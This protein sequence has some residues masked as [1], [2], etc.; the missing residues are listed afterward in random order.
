[1]MDEIGEQLSEVIEKDEPEMPIVPKFSEKYTS[2][3][4]LCENEI[5]ENHIFEKL[6]I[7]TGNCYKSSKVGLMRV[8]NAKRVIELWK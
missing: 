1:M 2:I 5:D 6:K 4:I 3:V 8:I 7:E